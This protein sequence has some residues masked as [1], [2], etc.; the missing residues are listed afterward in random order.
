MIKVLDP[1]LY[2]SI[3]DL[4]RIG[5]KAYGVPE[6]GAMDR[7]SAQL[8]NRLL[9]NSEQSAVLEMTMTGPKL[10]FNGNTYVC[11]TGACISPHLN[12]LPV[13]MDRVFEVK[14]GDI[15]S[16]SKLLYGFRGYLSVLG[17]IQS[18]SVLKS[19]SMYK[20]ISSQFKL[21]RGYEI[22]IADALQGYSNKHAGLK[23]KDSLFTRQK[24]QVFP[25]PEF[26]MLSEA[27]KNQLLQGEFTI[28]KNNNRMAYQL[29]E[30]LPNSLD[31][32]IT[33]MV[34]PGTVQLTPKGNLIILMRD[35]QTTGG[36]PRVLQ[37]SEDAINV[38]AQKFVGQSI[39]F[40]LTT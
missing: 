33:S 39:Q 5:Y 7:Q 38:L 31:D 27:Q 17:G 16:F 19:R 2:T 21:E 3:Q 32:I 9:S 13:A 28:S 8:G 26:E 4:G 37:L 40:N 35:C 10:Q 36:Y 25:G 23:I 11:L 12:D 22:Q 24:L 30:L 15:L 1:G 20:G 6:S 34:L 29:N 18:E 14:N